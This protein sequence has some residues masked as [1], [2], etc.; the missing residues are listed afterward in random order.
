MSSHPEQ[1]V[2]VAQGGA[3][4]GLESMP[5]QSLRDR[6]VPVLH[7]VSA[8]HFRDVIAPAQQPVILRG[9]DLG[10]ATQRWTPE[11][12]KSCPS[13]HH[14]VSAHVCTEPHGELHSEEEKHDRS[15][16]AQHMRALGR[17]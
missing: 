17:L 3:H 15:A 13:S 16:L 14:T 5:Q 7:A 12:L 2:T 4:G 1:H 9:L 8:Q 6:A 11:Y 10:P